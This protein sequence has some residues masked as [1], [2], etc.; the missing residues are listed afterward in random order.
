MNASPKFNFQQNSNTNNN[1]NNIGSA[2]FDTSFGDSFRNIERENSDE[3]KREM[4]IGG[5]KEK[6]SYVK[7]TMCF[8]K[9]EIQK[10]FDEVKL[11]R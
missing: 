6:D 5:F 11:V 3:L 10:M 9:N 1:M 2:L 7:G 4:S 8:G